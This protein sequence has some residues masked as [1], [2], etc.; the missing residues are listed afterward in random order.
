M[1]SFRTELENPIVE[2]DILD[3]EK[4]IRLFRDGKID[5]EKFRSLR[6]ARG[7]YGQRQPGVQMIRIKFPFGRITTEQIYRLSEVSDTFSTGKLHL[8]TRQDVQIHYVSLDRTPELW[9]ELE[10]DAITIREACG[11]TVRNVTASHLAGVDPQEPFDVSPYAQGIFEYFLRKPFGQELGRK[12]KIALS[13]SDEDT[14]YTFM[15]DLGLIPK[16]KTI[17]GKEVRGFKVMIGGGLGAQPFPALVAYDFLPE[18]EVIPF[19][20]ATIRVFD[21][22][23]ERARRNKARI[24]YLIHEIGLDAFMQLV[25]AERPAVPNQK[26]AFNH[27]AVPEPTPPPVFAGNGTAPKNTDLFQAWKKSNVIPQKQEGFVAVQIKIKLGN[28]TTDQARKFADIV[29]QYAANDIRITINQG[30]LLRYVR[31]E[32]LIALYNALDEIGFTESGFDS[33][34]DITACP[35]T[36]TCNLG[37]SNS[38]ATAL[39]LERVIRDEYPDLIYNQDI[40]IKISGCMNSCGQHGLAQIG[41]HGSSIK[42]GDHTLPALQLLLGGGIVGDGI[43][44]FGDKIIKVPSKRAPQALRTLLDDYHGKAQENE[45]YNTYY[46]RQGKDYFYQLLK[47]LGNK[48]TVTDDE[49]IDWGNS[50]RYVQEVGVG[51]CAGV[52]IDL[53]QTLLF[54]AEEKAEW[55]AEALAEKLYA[56]SM[57]HSYSA[58]VSGAKAL[59]TSK[60]AKC[61]T[62]A[63][64]IRDFDTEFVDKGLIKLDQSFQNVALRIQQQKADAA[65]AQDYLNIAK[66]F[67]QQLRA[68]STQPSN[69]AVNTPS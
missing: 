40:K 36:D 44:R 32:S 49:Y 45:N 34:A 35:G 33:V 59:L 58:M 51:E 14:A 17:D 4:K 2:K 57:Y 41:F 62:Q 23:G 11:N 28:L 55:A 39:E 63:G 22:H 52:M 50:A 53:V 30:F 46:D 27:N 48:E 25:E 9:A 12:F 21:R 13:S 69:N 29:K 18:D 60:G 65:F 24:K 7:I 64:I 16:I 67:L 10:K 3:L 68:V 37:I 31:E 56:D 42:N 61:N 1:Q 20:E 38:T 54:E 15:H 5:D 43:G 19:I 47:E 66:D 26:V 8:T 6:L